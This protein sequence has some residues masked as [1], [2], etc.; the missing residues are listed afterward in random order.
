MLFGYFLH[1]L[2]MVAPVILSRY[3]ENKTSEHS[4]TGSA[5]VTKRILPQLAI[6]V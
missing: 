1:P 3:A 5:C 2:Y 6:K 4:K